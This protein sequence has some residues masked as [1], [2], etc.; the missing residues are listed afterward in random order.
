MGNSKFPRLYTR[1]TNLLFRI[2]R[3]V[4]LTAYTRIRV[5]VPLDEECGG[6]DFG[7]N[8]RRLPHKLLASE[9]VCIKSFSCKFLELFLHYMNCK[10]V[11]L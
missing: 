10:P 1:H 4:C 9:L 5:L 3:Y 8:L 6:L 11:S 7:D 2:A